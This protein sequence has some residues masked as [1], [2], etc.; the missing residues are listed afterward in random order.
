MAQPID[1]N[2]LHG[3]WVRVREEDTPTEQVYRPAGFPLP[4]SRGRAGLQFNE[5]GTFKR[6]GI[7]ATDI[8]NV[9]EGVWRL[10]HANAGSIRVE[11]AGKPQL[12][13]INEL[14][15]DRLTIKRVPS[16]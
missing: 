6:I 16:E 15:Q 11:E 9:R 13:E 2:L 10:D 12:L 7:G 1:V 3:H 8:S 5:D 14:K 4:P